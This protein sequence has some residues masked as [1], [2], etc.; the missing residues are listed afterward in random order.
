MSA[1]AKGKKAFL[2][3]HLYK[4]GNPYR[5]G[6]DDHQSW[7][8]GFNLSFWNNLKQVQLREKNVS[9]KK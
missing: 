4:K 6:T 1:F 2:N 7:E 9:A 3:Y 5:I 8:Y